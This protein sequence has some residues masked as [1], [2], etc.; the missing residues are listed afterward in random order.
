M[1]SFQEGETRTYYDAFGH[2][3]EG[4]W[5]AQ[6]HT[7]YFDKDKP[8]EI[9]CQDM[10]AYLASKAGLRQGERL[11]NVGCGRGGADRFLA[12]QYNM[13]VTGIDI[14]DR[15]LREAKIRATKEGLA[16]KITYVQ[17]SMVGIPV[18]NE[19]YNYVWAQQS[20]FHCHDKAKALCEFFRILK[21]GGH[22]AIEDTVL[23]DARA[24]TEVLESFGRRLQL[25]DINTIDEYQNLFGQTGFSFKNTE[26]LSLHLERTY[27][28][29][30][31]KIQKGQVTRP[32]FLKT[33]QL[34]QEGKLGC[35]Y[36]LIRKPL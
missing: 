29:V 16:D 17:A 21:P 10:N 4:I 11:M 3:Y 22:V 28:A 1:T 20:L 6:I 34:V 7:G 13:T 36:V 14:S 25:T 23:L 9:A 32:D 19:A 24:K 33:L 31:K 30:I 26:D 27:Q 12:R 35:M 8:L 5:S 2:V 18:S 15:Q